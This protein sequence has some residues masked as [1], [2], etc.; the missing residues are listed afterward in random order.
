MAQNIGAAYPGTFLYN[1][2]REEGWM[3]SEEGMVANAGFQV[4]SLSYPHLSEAEIFE[5]VDNFYKRFFFR[6]TKIA[7]IVGEMARDREVMKMRLK[8]G[9]EFM[10]FLFSREDKAAATPV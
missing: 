5:A 9:V 2:A 7:E 6:P 1:Q 10:K 3:R 8:E 4:S